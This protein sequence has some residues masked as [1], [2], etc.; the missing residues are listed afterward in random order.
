MLGTALLAGCSEDAAAPSESL[1]SA[2]SAPTTEALPVVGPADFPV[3]PAARTQD[4]AGAETFL[5]Y[6]I[7][8]L[9]RQQ[10]VPAGQPLR[11]LGPDCGECQRIARVFDETAA[12][13]W[14]YQGGELTLNDVPAPVMEGETAYVSFG[15][16]QEAVQRVDATGAPVDDGQDVAPN[17]FGG[18]N[19]IW[20]AA[21]QSWVVTGFGYG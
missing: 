11:D 19:L 10:A 14:R 21:S 18:I 17:V 5:R 4:A 8:L 9:E 1:P 15:I 13:G 12:S 2:T 6:W 16:R 3:P 7:D 20:S